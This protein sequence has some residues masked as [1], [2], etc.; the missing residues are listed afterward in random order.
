MRVAIRQASTFYWLFND[1]LGSTSKVANANGALHSQQ[2][3]KA[4]GEI[5]YTSGTLPTHYTYTGQ[6][7]YA[8]SSANDFGMI[9]YGA[10]FYDPYLNRWTSPDS[11]I[12]DPFDPIAFDRYAYSRNNPVR[13]VDPSGHNWWDVTGQYATGFVNEFLLRNVGWITP[14]GQ[15]DLGVQASESS[16][17]LIGR[18]AADA[19]TLVL[20]VENVATGTTIATGGTVVACGATLCIGAGAT[21]AGGV[22]VAAVGASQVGQGAIGLGGNLALLANKKQGGLTPRE[23]QRSISS[24][25]NNI[26]EHEA[27]LNAYIEDPYAFDN[28]G[29]LRNAPNDEVR[30]AIINGRINH[31]QH[32]IDN[33]RNQV[34]YLRGLLE[35][36]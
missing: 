3:Y 30:Q 29:L 34:D 20:G 27:K 15:R 13:Y 10:R 2:L 22:A 32:E 4:W 5:R 6:Y 12:P 25:E 35:N 23:I 18:I 7:T 16:A 28:Q 21:V 36:K 17:S 1:H 33:W 11:I 31:L 19:A 8:T 14:N 24:L 26:A 9:Y